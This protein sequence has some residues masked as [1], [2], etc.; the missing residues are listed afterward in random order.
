[1]GSIHKMIF[2]RKKQNRLYHPQ[3][4]GEPKDWLMCNALIGAQ[5]Y[6]ELGSPLDFND[7]I[8]PSWYVQLR[9]EKKLEKIW[10]AQEAYVTDLLRWLDSKDVTEVFFD[11]AYQKDEN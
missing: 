2:K 11:G 4:Q 10:R 5:S 3:D 9:D 8:A 1:M 6:A 7:E